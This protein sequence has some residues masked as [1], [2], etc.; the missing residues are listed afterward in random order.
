MELIEDE[1]P[2]AAS[3][4]FKPIPSRPMEGFDEYYQQPVDNIESDA[5]KNDQHIFTGK[6]VF[7]CVLLLI[8]VV[9]IGTGIGVFLVDW[10]RPNSK[11]SS[12][13]K[14]D[15]V[16]KPK[17]V[18]QSKN[19]VT[20]VVTSKK[21]DL[22]LGKIMIGMSMSD[23]QS[24]LGVDKG[25]DL[26]DGYRYHK[27]DGLQVGE[28]DGTVNAVVSSGASVKTSRGLHEGST[29]DEMVKAYGTD[30]MTMKLANLMLYEYSFQDKLGRKGLLRFAVRDI[31]K[32]VDYISIRV[33]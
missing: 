9:S 7:V 5:P 21:T 28:K 16:S 25:V 1:I 24:I 4:G 31:D 32:R 17:V 29:Y 26:N 11:A 8:F 30:Y 18:E 2:S 10:S 20:P 19:S 14:Q 22:S 13:P 3:L 27:Y 6:R 12:V 23:V 33:I 15:V